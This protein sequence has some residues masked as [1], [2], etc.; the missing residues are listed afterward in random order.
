MIE[1]KKWVLKYFAEQKRA[2]LESAQ[3]L[4]FD[5]QANRALAYL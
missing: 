5:I 3:T 1:E 4:L 2:R